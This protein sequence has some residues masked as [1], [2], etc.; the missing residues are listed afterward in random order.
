MSPSPD[1]PVVLGVINFEGGGRMFLMMTDKDVDQVKI[2]MKVQVSFRKL[3]FNEGIHNYF[4]KCAPER[5]S[6]G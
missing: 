6:D 3:F 5:F 2:G 4:W 1:P